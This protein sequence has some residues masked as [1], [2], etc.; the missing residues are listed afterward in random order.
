MLPNQ[1]LNT[2]CKTC[3]QLMTLTAASLKSSFC[4][5]FLLSAQVSAS[6]SVCC[7]RQ[8]SGR[9]RRQKQG[10]QSRGKLHVHTCS[11]S[12]SLFPV[13]TKMCC[14]AFVQLVEKVSRVFPLIFKS[15]VMHWS[16]SLLKLED[17]KIWPAQKGKGEK[18]FNFFLLVFFPSENECASIATVCNLDLLLLLYN[19]GVFY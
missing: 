1:H 15:V 16:A 3:C 2:L 13:S 14:L 17:I 4:F 5:D 9:G 19:V 7:W 10:S 12:L 6:E 11:W 18:L 8:T